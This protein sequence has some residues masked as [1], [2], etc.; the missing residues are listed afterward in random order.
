MGYVC[1]DV[2]C[3][4]VPK[5]HTSRLSFYTFIKQSNP[6][7]QI[8]K[9]VHLWLLIATYFLLA[10]FYMPMKSAFSK[11]NASQ[12]FRSVI[13]S[14]W[15]QHYSILPTYVDIVIYSPSFIIFHSHMHQVPSYSYF[16]TRDISAKEWIDFCRQ[17]QYF[18]K[19]FLGYMPPDL[20]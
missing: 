11:F 9:S 17:I 19:T 2:P 18:F 8:L 16:L 4:L 15:T 7:S 10:A 3:H 1:T 5:L 14:Y 6:L 12:S 20:Y 13:S